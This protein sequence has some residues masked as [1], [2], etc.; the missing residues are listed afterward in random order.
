MTLFTAFKTNTDAEVTGRWFDLPTL[1]TD[2]TKPGFKL[3]R[4]ATTN[5]VYQTAIERLS[6]EL[7]R[8]IELDL[9][10]EAVAGPV[11]RGVFVDTILKD[12]RNIYDEQDQPLDFSKEAAAELFKVLPDLYLMLVEEARKLANYRA[13][14]IALISGK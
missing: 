8:D 14:S 7:R 2:G 6:K 1:N 9:L 12:W 11:M 5:P 3:A 13:E 10:T 4:M